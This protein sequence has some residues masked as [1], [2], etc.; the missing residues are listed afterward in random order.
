M[1]FWGAVGI[2]QGVHVFLSY[3]ERYLK[4]ELFGYELAGHDALLV[5]VGE[6]HGFL[7]DIIAKGL[8]IIFFER[9]FI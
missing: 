1:L 7:L 2:D 6:E 5:E 8:F 9:F 3:W 4:G